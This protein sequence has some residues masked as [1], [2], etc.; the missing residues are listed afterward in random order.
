MATGLKYF[1]F[2]LFLPG[3]L[4]VCA[5]QPRFV[6][7]GACPGE[8]C[9]YGETWIPRS[10]VSLRARPSEDSAVLAV[11]EAGA[12]V[13]TIGGEVHTTPSLFHVARQHGVFRPGDEIWVYTYLGEGYFRVL[14]NGELK[15]ADLGFSP[16]GGT[17]GRRCEASPRCWGTLEASLDFDWWVELRGPGGVIGWTRDTAKFNR[18]PHD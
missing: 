6:D 8:G 16:W 10:P 9:G 17:A 13:M 3:A 14:H 5:A 2:L 11:L 1:S 18:L 7:K 12:E 15:E 4:S